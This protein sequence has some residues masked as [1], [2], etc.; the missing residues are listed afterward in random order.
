[1]GQTQGLGLVWQAMPSHSAA[2][3]APE[4]LISERIQESGF[5]INFTHVFET[6]SDKKAQVGL[7][8]M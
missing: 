8:L 1:M 5:W 2:K 3:L 6:R 4:L 7:G